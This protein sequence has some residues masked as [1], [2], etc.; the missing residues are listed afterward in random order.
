[1]LAR[2]LKHNQSARV[3]QQRQV[4]GCRIATGYRICIGFVR[5]C[6]QLSNKVVEK[7]SV[8]YASQM[9]KRGLDLSCRPITDCPCEQPRILATIMAQRKLVENQMGDTTAGEALQNP[10][11]DGKCQALVG[12]RKW[13]EVYKVP[14]EASQVSNATSRVPSLHGIDGSIPCGEKRLPV[15][16]ANRSWR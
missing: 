14:V 8:V 1:M 13:V 15:S 12:A 7:L 16:V 3:H 4:R 9:A 11:H 5:R 10:V 2:P 6:C